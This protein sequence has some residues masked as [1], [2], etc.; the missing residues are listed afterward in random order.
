MIAPGCAIPRF[1]HKLAQLH[2]CLVSGLVKRHFAGFHLKELG[3]FSVQMRADVR[4]REELRL[5]IRHRLSIVRKRS[6]DEQSE[7]EESGRRSVFGSFGGC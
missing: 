1:S 5:E 7:A 4:S 2:E 6:P 3:W